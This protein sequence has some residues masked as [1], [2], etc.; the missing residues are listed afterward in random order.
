MPTSFSILLY[1][2]QFLIFKSIDAPQQYQVHYPVG[3]Y[4]PF[5]LLF[6]LS[7]FSFYHYHI[8]FGVY[9]LQ[10]LIWRSL[11]YLFWRVFPFYKC[12]F[13]CILREKRTLLNNILCRKANWIGHILRRN[14]LL[15]DA[16]EGLMTKVKGVGRRRRTQLLNDLN[17][18][19]IEHKE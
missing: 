14:C 15:H 3:S 13:I 6:H 10:L 8:S 7:R 18:L 11:H 16:I 17:S 19:W 9:L 12:S 5:I 4:Y 2:W 1:G